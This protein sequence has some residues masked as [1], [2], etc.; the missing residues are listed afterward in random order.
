VLPLVHDGEAH[1]GGPFAFCKEGEGGTGVRRKDLVG[2]CRRAVLGED[3]DGTAV[4]KHP[5]PYPTIFQLPTLG[6]SM[7]A[8]SSAMHSARCSLRWL[9]ARPLTPHPMRAMFYITSGNAR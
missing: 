3:L 4:Q 7:G 6:T 1:Q 5:K 2:D 8:L 9:V